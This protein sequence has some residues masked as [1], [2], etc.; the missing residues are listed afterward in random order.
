MGTASNLWPHQEEALEVLRRYLSDP[1]RSGAA[2]VA[3]PTGTGKSAVVAHLLSQGAADEVN[4]SSLVLVPW[5]SLAKQLTSDLN[6]RVWANLGLPRPAAMP[7]ARL[8]RSSREFRERDVAEADPALYV[9]T[10]AMASQIFQD[11]D[12]EPAEM[13]SLFAPFRTLIV[14]ECHYE[15]APTWS[16]A[17]RAT[18]L[19][20]CLLTATPYRNDNLFFDVSESATYRFAHKEAERQGILRTPNFVTLDWHATEASFVEALLSWLKTQSAEVGESRVLI[21]CAS[22]ES[23]REI[24]RLLRAADEAA[25]GYHENFKAADKDGHLYGSVPAPNRRSKARFLVH[26][27]KLTEGFDDPELRVLAV[28]DGFANDRSRVQQIGRILRNPDY[29]RPANA[30]VLSQ[31]DEMERAWSRYSRFDG[32]EGPRSMASDPAGIESLLEAQPETFYWDRLF[33][34][35]V[36]LHAERPWESV[37]FA[38]STVARTV[39]GGTP[40]L[41]AFAEGVR[42]N[43]AQRDRRVLSSGSPTPSSRFFLYLAVENSPVLRDSAFVEMRLGY[44]LLHWDGSH[45]FVSDSEAIPKFVRDNSDPV[46]PHSLMGLIPGGARVSGVS[47]KN[48][49]LGEWALRAR[50]VSARDLSRVASELG[51]STFGFSTATGHIRI[52]DRIITRYAGVGNGRVRDTRASEGRLEDILAWFDELGSRLSE[53]SEPARAI[54]RYARPASPP[55]EV[56]AR[57]V[58]LDVEPDDFSSR[59]DSS[60]L[61]VHDYGSEVRDGCFQ[62]L[63]NGERHGA[64]ISW[65]PG[66]RRFRVVPEA[67]LNYVNSVGETFWDAVNRR[68]AFRV[69]IDGLVYT[70]GGFWSLAGRSSADRRS[71]LSILESRPSLAHTQSEKAAIADGEWPTTC[72][73]G[74]ADRLLR[75]PRFDP[76]VT[77]LCTDMGYEIADF[78]AHDDSRVV[79]VHVKNNNKGAEATLSAS[80]LHEVVSQAVKNLRYLTIGNSDRPSVGSWNR[81]WNDGKHPPAPRLRRGEPA[82]TGETYWRRVDKKIQSH[83]YQRELWLVVGKSLSQSELRRQLARDEPSAIAVQVYSLLTALASAARQC[84]VGVRVFC[85]P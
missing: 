57:H 53:A 73:F 67:H 29:P 51:D 42:S 18:G 30:V 82:K 26:Q 6:V 33:R 72:A 71:V 14:D 34:Q 40:N 7:P 83:G 38:L 21:R 54:T 45:L 15:P 43:L 37:R 32:G 63:I 23:V 44:T 41:D 20:T 68:Q 52:E 13:G 5:R 1:N 78:I 48:N 28:F 46:E 8:I 85:S 58:L 36:D 76:S 69:A 25:V 62:V 79:F 2:L 19:P 49:D 10:M 61:R 22:G 70:N 77:V 75:T 4:K 9:G 47:L 35:Q 60:P 24:V 16:L 17:A 64:R 31:D 65:E 80:S 27:H 11:L 59:I 74:E 3:M 81:D 66:A 56:H 84:G 12:E 55:H 39:P 50:A